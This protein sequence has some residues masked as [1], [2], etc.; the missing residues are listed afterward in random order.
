MGRRGCVIVTV[1]T[2]SSV[3]VSISLQQENIPVAIEVETE[4][5]VAVSENDVTA[6]II[7]HE[8]M[9]EVLSETAKECI[10]LNAKHP[11][12]I[13]YGRDTNMTLFFSK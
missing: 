6:L 5:V 1:K 3:D 8:I 9:E 10:I 7:Y 4:S 2:H 12:N 13:E 11:C